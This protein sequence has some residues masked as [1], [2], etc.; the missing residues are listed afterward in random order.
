MRNK[1]GWRRKKCKRCANI[2]KT[3]G[4]FVRVCP[5]CDKRP[6][7]YRSRIKDGETIIKKG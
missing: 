6:G 5:K 2:F 3:K 7:R 4:K 1:D